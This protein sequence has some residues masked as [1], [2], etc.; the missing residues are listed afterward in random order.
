MAFD[1]GA[2]SCP[3]GHGHPTAPVHAPASSAVCCRA[4]AAVHGDCPRAA[5]N[6]AT[7]EVTADVR[8]NLGV[9]GVD[10]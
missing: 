10:L 4:A 6:A 8:E 3:A 5:A 9:P 1:T 7:E 2:A